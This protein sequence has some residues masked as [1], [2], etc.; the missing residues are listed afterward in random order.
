MPKKFYVVWKGKEPGVYADWEGCRRQVEHFQGAKYKAFPDEP[1]ARR[2][3]A[4][5]PEAHLTQKPK[6]MT[7]IFNALYGKPEIP[8]IAVDGACN[9]KTR[10]AE[11][12]GVLTETGALLFHRGPFPEGTNNIMEFLAIVH[13]L[14]YCVQQ[15]LDVPVYSD[16]MTAI[17][18]VRQKK[19]ATKLLRT[20]R[21]AKL[22]ELME[23]AERW[24]QTHTW[25]NRLLKWETQAWGEIPADFGR[26]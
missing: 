26:K 12:R 13:A 18:W 4:E 7:P 16:S 2:A 15:Q 5:G 19:T 20:E 8:S 21:N 10:D 25:P 9:G 23:R 24:L 11:Y 3:F 1:S 6:A 22:F 14:A 17:K